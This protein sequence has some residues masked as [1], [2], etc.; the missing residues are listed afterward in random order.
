MYL[1][2]VLR[3]RIANLLLALA[4]RIQIYPYL[5]DE[6][7]DRVCEQLTEGLPVKRLGVGLYLYDGHCRS[8]DHQ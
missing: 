2:I 8:K 7:V 3:Q 6:Q 5:S 1:F 4:S